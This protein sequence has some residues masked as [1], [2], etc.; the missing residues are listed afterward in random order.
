[1]FNISQK[2]YHHS[3]II[4]FIKED[5]PC[6]QHPLLL[7]VLLFLC[8][9]RLPVLVIGQVEYQ[10][11]ELLLKLGIIR[12]LLEQ[13]HVVSHDGEDDLLQ[14]TVAFSTGILLVA[15]THCI[16]VLLITADH[17][18]NL[19]NLAT[20]V[21]SI[22]P[23]DI[24]E[25]IIELIQNSRQQNHLRVALASGHASRHRPNLC[26]LIREDKRNGVP[27]F[28][29]IAVQINSIKDALRQ[30]FF[31][32]RRELREKHVQEDGQ[33]FPFRISIGQD[34]T[35]EPICTNKAF[36]RALELD[37]SVGIQLLAYCGTCIQNRIEL[38]STSAIQITINQHFDMVVSIKTLI[39]INVTGITRILRRKIN[40]IGFGISAISLIKNL[41][42]IANNSI[43]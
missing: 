39:N 12:I 14:H 2:H 38:I 13:L 41:V 30:I 17:A 42:S 1:M 25:H 4:M 16:L 18:G 3:N 29:T 5:T 6:L 9:I 11:A 40:R 34:S 8:L 7:L 32:R 36:C 35:Q 24:A 19:H 22:I 31:L 37:L 28:D 15:V 21:I 20:D 33:L 27:L 43:E 23:V 10:I 26:I